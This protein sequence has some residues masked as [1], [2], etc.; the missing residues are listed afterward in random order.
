MGFVLGQ[1]KNGNL[2]VLGGNQSDMVC[3][4][5]FERSRVL[6]YRWPPGLKVPEAGDLPIIAYKGALSSNE[7]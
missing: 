5:P 6:G 3:I 1:D 2:I 4:K 7:A